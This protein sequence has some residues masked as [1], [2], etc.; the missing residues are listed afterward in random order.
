MFPATIEGPFLLEVGGR[1]YPDE[2]GRAPAVAFGGEPHPKTKKTQAWVALYGTPKKEAGSK[3]VWMPARLTHFDGKSE[4]VL[5][6]LENVPVKAGTRFRVQ[7]KV[8]KDRIQVAINGK[9]LFSQRRTPATYGFT[10]FKVA[11]WSHVRFAG[12]IEPS[13]VQDRLDKNRQAALAKFRKTYEK[14]QFLPAWLFEGPASVA[15]A[16]KKPRRTLPVDVERKHRGVL[17]RASSSIKRR[18]WAAARRAIEQL[19]SADVPKATTDWLAAQVSLGEGSL[20]RGLEELEACLT[21]EPQFLDGLL[22]KGRLLQRLG[23]PD[24]AYRVFKT[25]IT[26]HGA[27]PEAYESAAIAMLVAGRPD[28]AKKVTETAAVA[29]VRSKD[30]DLLAR[31]VVK[32]DRGPTWGETFEYRSRNYHVVSDMSKQICIEA[33]KLLEEALTSYRVNMEWVS[34]DKTKLY[35]VYLFSGRR[36]FHDYLAELGPLLGNVP[37]GVAG[38]YSPLLKQ[39]V[40]WHLPDRDAMLET[41]RHEGFHQYL[42]RF[43]PDAPV[44]FNEGLAVYHENATKKRGKLHFGEPHAFYLDVLQKKGLV[45]LEDFLHW[46]RADFYPAAPHSYA[47]AWALMHLLREGTAKQRALF[48]TLLEEF[49]NAP[50]SEV[51]RKHFPASSLGTWKTALEAHIGRLRQR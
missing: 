43:M 17:R 3:I 32:A 37:M 47:Q 40:I 27:E 33:A 7:L 29:G 14:E 24:E 41:I 38:L 34:R 8:T 39:L 4:K 35:K 5:D 46:T 50:P 45:P 11:N 23:D 6:T 16:P 30:L 9:T 26:H 20:S 13:W 12:V 21:A 25:A 42:D 19:R 31:V 2:P 1:Q 44:W 48:K 22:L 15:T 28:A 10:R 18:D 36:G 51:I 49:Q